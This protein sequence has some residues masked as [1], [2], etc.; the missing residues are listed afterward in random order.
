[1]KIAFLGFDQ[2]QGKFDI[3]SSGIRCDWVIK[4][5]PEAERFRQGGKYDAII[6]QKA[7][8]VDYMKAYKG[9]KI[10]DM[11]DPDW[12][13]AHSR[14]IETIHEAHAITCSSPELA[15]AVAKLTNKPVWCV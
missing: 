2:W 10:L 5:W 12:M 3:G 7:Y 6:F 13:E 8:W 14:V 1:M 15:K 9:V 4:H 11:C